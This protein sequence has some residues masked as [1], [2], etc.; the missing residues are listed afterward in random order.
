MAARFLPLLAVVLLSAGL[1]GCVDLSA[2]APRAALGA[3][4]LEGATA[5]VDVPVLAVAQT[6]QGDVGIA[7]TATV[8]VLPGHGVVYVATEPATETDTQGSATTAAREAAAEAG[9]PFAA[10]DYLVHFTSDAELVG[11]PSAGAAMALAFYVALHDL[12][13]PAHKVSI[14]PKVAMTGTIEDDGSIGLIGGA[15]AKAHAVADSGRSTFL[16]PRGQ[17]GEQTQTRGFYQRT[18]EVPLQPTCDQLKIVCGEVPDLHALVRAAT[19]AG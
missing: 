3:V 10:H 8:E 19:V 18:V 17:T 11:G 7:Y 9:V 15:I 12:A 2:L 16:V 1:A 5:Q 4:R 13:D 6:R 14:A